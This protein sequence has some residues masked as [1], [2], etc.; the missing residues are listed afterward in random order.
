MEG[1]LKGIEWDA[2]EHHHTK[3]SSDWFWVL[4]IVTISTT[5]ASILLNNTLLGII[6]L[7]GGMVLALL[8]AR[9]PKTVLYAVTLRG[10]RV[11]DK[12]YPYTTLETYCIEDVPNTGPQLLV[13]SEKLFM[14]LIIMPLPEEHVDEIEDIIAERLPEEHLEEPL[15]NKL[16]EFFGF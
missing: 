8:S 16:L 2:H 3:K 15:V 7:I 4:G 11:D 5:V 6:F 12:L 9:E 13:K 10:L 1:Q 14:P